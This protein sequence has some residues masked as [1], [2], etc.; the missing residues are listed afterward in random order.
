VIVN[1]QASHESGEWVVAV[2]IDDDPIQYF[3][4]NSAGYIECEDDPPDDA[5]QGEVQ[6]FYM[7][8]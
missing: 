2:Q 5:N 1:V 4:L 8:D 7:E 3:V 6:L